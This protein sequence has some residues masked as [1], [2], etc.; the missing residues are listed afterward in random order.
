MTFLV[1]DVP[2]HKEPRSD[3]G[4]CVLELWRARV[5]TVAVLLHRGHADPASQAPL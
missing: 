3:T 1:F 5:V 4:T 2:C